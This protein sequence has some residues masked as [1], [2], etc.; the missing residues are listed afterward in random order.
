MHPGS[1]K[2]EA[3]GR[4]TRPERILLV[5]D[6]PCVRDSLCAVLTGEGYEVRTAEN[7]VR[8]LELAALR[9]VDLVLL[10]LNMPVKDGWATLQALSRD[11]PALPVALL[12]ARPNQLFPAL[13]AG[14]AALLEKPLDIPHLLRTI[15]QLLDE[16]AQAQAR[17]SA[18]RKADFYYRSPLQHER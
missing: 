18:G 7:G 10:D 13:A 11:Y 8:A 14:V 1:N 15:R 16:P 5:D 3:H 17:R 2:K 9:N 4:P 12:T 6:D